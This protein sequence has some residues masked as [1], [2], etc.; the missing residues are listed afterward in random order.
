MYSIETVVRE[1][2]NNVRKEQKMLFGTGRLTNDPPAI[3]DVA[4]GYQVMQGSKDHRFSMA[5]NNGRDK[6]GNEK[7]ATF[8]NIV[9][10]GKSAEIMSKIGYKGR[11]V[12]VV[13]RVEKQSYTNSNGEPVEYEVLVIERFDAKGK[14]KNA[15]NQ[16]NQN[17][18]YNNQTNNSQPELNSNDAV[19]VDPSEDDIPF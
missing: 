6:D 9:L 8:Y 19:P 11:E 18:Q 10:W 2:K 17:N 15:E 13:G 1:D 12:E 16:N 7:P 5:F 3:K 4:G 14:S